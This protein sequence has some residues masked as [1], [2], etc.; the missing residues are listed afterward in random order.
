MTIS[1]ISVF[2]IPLAENMK[3]VIVNN[4]KSEL[5]HDRSQAAPRVEMKK[6]ASIWF[7]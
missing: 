2:T 5:L 6:N 7:K 3:F 1:L 4:I